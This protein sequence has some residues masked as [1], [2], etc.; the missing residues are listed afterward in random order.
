MTNQSASGANRPNAIF[1]DTVSGTCMDYSEQYNMK[2]TSVFGGQLPE[3][4]NTSMGLK[5]SDVLASSDN[6]NFSD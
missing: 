3:V 4:S 1:S 6:I 5:N 2:S